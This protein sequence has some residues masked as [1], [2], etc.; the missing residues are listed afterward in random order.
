[1]TT[2]SLVCTRGVADRLGAVIRVVLDKALS[3]QERNLSKAGGIQERVFW[4][5]CKGIMNRGEFNLAPF[6]PSL[7]SYTRHTRRAIATLLELDRWVS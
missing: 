5:T 3:R 4:G 2:T 1:M 6:L 7:S